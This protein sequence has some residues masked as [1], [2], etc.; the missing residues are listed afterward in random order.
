[1]DYSEELW[2]FVKQYCG[3]LLV[4]FNGHLFVPDFSW[5]YFSFCFMERNIIFEYL[6]GL[7]T[8]NLILEVHI[9]IFP[10]LK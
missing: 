9:H 4:L 2:Q 5:H 6:Y 7:L 10:Y 1:M 3:I 8:L